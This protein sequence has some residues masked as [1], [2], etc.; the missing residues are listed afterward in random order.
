METVAN[1]T[2]VKT[3][4]VIIDLRK[5]K[6]KKIRQLKRGRGDLLIEVDQAIATAANSLGKDAAGKTLVPVVI[7]YR[8]KVKKK[9]A[10]DIFG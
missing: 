2:T 5:V 6:Q 10:K 4:P 8:N 9:K 7:L 3:C 1:E